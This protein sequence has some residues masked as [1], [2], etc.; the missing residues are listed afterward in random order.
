M[1]ESPENSWETVAADW[2]GDKGDFDQSSLV[3]LMKSCHLWAI[4]E[5]SQT[6]LVYE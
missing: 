2:V 3:E 6:G 4:L 5:V 1:K